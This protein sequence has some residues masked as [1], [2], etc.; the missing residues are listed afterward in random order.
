[1][2]L[3]VSAAETSH[4]QVLVS[5]DGKD[6]FPAVTVLED[7][8][9]QLPDCCV[10]LPNIIMDKSRLFCWHDTVSILINQSINQLIKKMA[11]LSLCL[12]KGLIVLCLLPL[13]PAGIQ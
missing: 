8:Y 1:M 3:L 12:F 4:C 2:R 11:L 7:W 10:G 13:L 6:E 5:A 9:K